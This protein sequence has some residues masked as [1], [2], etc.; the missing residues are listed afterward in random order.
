VADYSAFGAA[1]TVTVTASTVDTFTLS[2]I[3]TPSALEV[4]H[5]GNTSAPLYVKVDDAVAAPTVAGDGFEVVL[6]G[7][8]VR[9]A[10]VGSGTSVVSL[11]SA[12]AT[13]VTVIGVK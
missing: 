11:I 8:R 7:E 9:F 3:G 4:V 12:G 2:G 5:H 10:R 1:K 13:T 6:P